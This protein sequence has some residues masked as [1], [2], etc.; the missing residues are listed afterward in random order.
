MSSLTDHVDK[1]FISDSADSIAD[2]IAPKVKKQLKHKKKSKKKKHKSEKKRSKDFNVS[3]ENGSKKRKHKKK[4]HKHASEQSSE[5]GPLPQKRSKIEENLSDG[6]I[7]DIKSAEEFVSE[8]GFNSVKNNQATL[9]ESVEE[10]EVADDCDQLR[11]KLEVTKDLREEDLE[12]GECID[13]ESVVAEVNRSGNNSHVHAAISSGNYDL[14]RK[15]KS[16]ESKP[17]SRK[18]PKVTHRDGDKSMSRPRK[19]RTSNVTGSKSANRHD[20]HGKEERPRSRPE[21][22]RAS[23]DHIRNRTSSGHSKMDPTKRR[24]RDREN[25]PRRQEQRPS[26]RARAQGDHNRRDSRD[27]Q[28]GDRRSGRTD[29]HD[30]HNDHQRSSHRDRHSRR[31]A[32]DKYKGSFSEGQKKAWEADSDS[33]VENIVLDDSE[34]EEELAKQAEIRR[35]NSQMDIIKEFEKKQ[36]ENKMNGR[37][38]GLSA[39]A[40]DKKLLEGGVDDICDLMIDDDTALN[41]KTEEKITPDS[42]ISTPHAH[43]E[44]HSPEPYQLHTLDSGDEPR[45]AE[46]NGLEKLQ[47]EEEKKQ[48][49]DEE[50]FE[51]SDMFSE[52]FVPNKQK[53]IMISSNDNQDANLQDNWTDSDGYYRV[54]VGDQLD[55]SRYHVISFTGQ[56]VFSNVVLALDS[57]RGDSTVAIKIIRKNELMHKTGLKELE[58]LKKLNETDRDDKYHCLRLYGHFQHKSHLCLVSESLSMNLREL[59]KKYGGG[60]G[61]NV[62]AVQRYAQQ[63]FLALKLMKKCQLVHADIKPD[64]ILVNKSRTVLKLCDFGS[65]CHVADQDITPYRVSR[66][67]RAPEI[68]LGMKFDFAIDIW[69]VACTIYELCTGKILFKGINNNVMLKLMMDLKGKI[70]HRVIKKG[71]L[72]DKYF[73]THFNFK[74]L[75]IDRVTEREKVTIMPTINQTFDLRKEIINSQT[76]SHRLPEDQLNTMNQL[77]DLLDK[78]L[79]LDPTKR[80]T[81]N[82][83]LV[84][85][86]ITQKIY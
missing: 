61:I 40:D 22:D 38:R 69:S 42:T 63:L 21:H 30:R 3:G 77:I 83:A 26:I 66:F 58:F 34:D 9:E 64:N 24:S 12:L 80:L 13:S 33:E 44:S 41:N 1:K 31:D 16:S 62:K 71:E 36:S 29:R 7:V 54:M 70:P 23:G 18:S 84:H 15:R 2:E 86:F 47:L 74:F 37:V 79:Q 25:R 28:R 49:E 35:K 81:I 59:L 76:N 8:A 65:A 20:H 68:I 60:N 53:K 19:K 55:K 27:R 14:H 43:E 5:E 73:D 6:E 4:K 57:A 72:K 48:Q 52:N 50:I 10:G 67:Y 51:T 56:G 85:P 82:E 78:S 75:E 11:E 17:S 39:V 32:E 46:M 45:L